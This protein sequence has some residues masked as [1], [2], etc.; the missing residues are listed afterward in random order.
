MTSV[1]RRTLAIVAASALGGLLIFAVM[2]YRA[3]DVEEATAAQALSEFERARAPLVGQVPLVV[4]AADGSV[5]A[6]DEKVEPV[7][8]PDPVTTFRVLAFRSSGGQLA[9]ATVPFWFFRLKRPAAQLAL[10]GTGLDLDR[11]GL[12]SERLARR[13]PGL[14]LDQASPNGDRLLVWTE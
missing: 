7:A 1:L 3:V 11:L 10:R 2:V 13:G 5:Q 6:N 14:V 9:R 4:V 12:T 8:T